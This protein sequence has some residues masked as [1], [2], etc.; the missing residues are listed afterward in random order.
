MG[1]TE[2]D[3]LT[4]T[5]TVVEGILDLIRHERLG[6]ASDQRE[7]LYEAVLIATAAGHPDAQAMARE[8]LRLRG[9]L[10]CR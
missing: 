4:E 5:R 7:H 10:R 1:G 6:P 2:M 3:S 9:R 8:A